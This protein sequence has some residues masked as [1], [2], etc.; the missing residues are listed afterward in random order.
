VY[1]FLLE[2][3][4]LFVIM[5]LY[6][7]KERRQGQVAAVFLIGY[8]VLRFI[9]EYFSEPDDFLGLRALNLSQGQWLSVPMVVFGIGLWIW[10]AQR[11]QP[12]SA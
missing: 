4:L 11:R 6:A 8:G 10:A 5:W 7:R 12:A 1:Q 3:L 9:A 2:G